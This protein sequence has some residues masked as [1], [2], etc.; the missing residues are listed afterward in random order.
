MLRG[1][2]ELAPS[3]LNEQIL[4]ENL[5]PCKQLQM[6]MPMMTMMEIKNPM[7]TTNERLHRNIVWGPRAGIMILI[8]IV[9]LNILSLID[10]LLFFF[11][12]DDYLMFF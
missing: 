4:T 1:H 9:F 3:Y 7:C 6:T 11:T 5:S 8:K 12:L 10:Y 2:F